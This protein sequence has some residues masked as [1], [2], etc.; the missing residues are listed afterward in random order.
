MENQVL[1]LAESVFIG[2][3]AGFFGTFALMAR[4]L[5]TGH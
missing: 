5:E 4:T 2:G 1:G 3:L